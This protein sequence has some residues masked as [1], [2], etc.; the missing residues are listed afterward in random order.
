VT[1][2]KRLS[3]RNDLGGALLG[4]AIGDAPAP[5]ARARTAAALGLGLG[6]G[7]AAGGAAAVVSGGAAKVA[8]ASLAPKAIGAGTGLGAK[9]AG[10][11][12]LKL[13]AAGVVAVAVAGGVAAVA[14]KPAKDHA[15]TTTLERGRE[16]AATVAALPPTA[17][18]LTTPPEVPAPVVRPEPAAAAAPA[19]APTTPTK[20]LAS[21]APIEGSLAR[22]LRSLDEARSALGRGDA[23]GTLAELDRHDRAFPGG[24]LRTEAKML[25]AEALLARGD[26][27]AARKLAAELLARDPS[28]LHARRLRTIADSAP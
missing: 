23:T 20:V 8:G 10:A 14:M 22:E 9:A 1:E 7:L 17:P 26:R 18:I 6:A 19:P 2:P 13:F 4:S 21:A 25:R 15:D 5:G 24:A 16:T 3:S 28:G 27:A 12:W 11:L